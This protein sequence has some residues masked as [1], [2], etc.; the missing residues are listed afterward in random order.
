M[1]VAEASLELRWQRRTVGGEVDSP[2]VRSPSRAEAVDEA[3]HLYLREIGRFPLLAAEQERA[4]ARRAHRGDASAY[5]QLIQSNLRLVVN[6]AGKSTGYGV[7]VLDLIQE[8]NIGLMHAARLFDPERGVRF[9]TYATWWIR[10][11]IGRA[12]IDQSRA[13]RLPPP[14]HDLDVRVR[15][16]QARLNGELG[17]EATLAEIAASLR[18]P[19]SKLQNLIA[20]TRPMCS[21]QARLSE[22][23][24]EGTLEDLVPDPDAV[25]PGEGILD[26]A[27]RAEIDGL[28]RTL[29]G[30]ERR[31]IA[32]RFGLDGGVPRTLETIGRRLGVTRQRVQQI[33][34]EAMAKLR[35][36][37]GCARLR[38]FA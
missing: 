3:L 21:L 38:E 11:A 28:L 37:E 13:V 6:L 8:G 33:E 26:Y 16:T 24:D 30:R 15:R 1:S 29:T 32:A 25:D 10:Q 4:L 31:V 34:G 2:A 23:R 18:Q 20:W 17:R 9:S 5:T 12:V 27:L 19:L 14:L 7:P 36:S 35:H 22:D